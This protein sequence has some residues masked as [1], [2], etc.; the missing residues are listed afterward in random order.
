M[1]RF[2]QSGGLRCSQEFHK[3]PYIWGLFAY[4]SLDMVMSVV[5]FGLLDK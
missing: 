2:L 5:S 4:S 3:K 1:V